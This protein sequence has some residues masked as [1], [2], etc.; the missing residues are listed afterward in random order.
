MKHKSP[1]KTLRDV[2]RMTRFLYKKNEYK[3]GLSIQKLASFDIP[4]VPVPKPVLSVVQIQTTN[5]RPQPK[6]RLSISRQTSVDIPPEQ[7]TENKP[8]TMQDFMDIAQ[9]SENVCK[10]EVKDRKQEREKN[11]LEFKRSMWFPP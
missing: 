6:L 10:Q 5:V 11:L 8:F 4:P 7:K 2:I 3:I 9:K 1:A